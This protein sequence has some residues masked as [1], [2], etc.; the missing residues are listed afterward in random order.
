M[1]IFKSKQAAFTL[2]EIILV[3]LILSVI[4]CLAIPNFGQTYSQLQL[5]QTTE[6]LA[7]LM[8][9]AQTFAISN[10]Q[11]VQL[12]FDSEFSS[13]WLNKSTADTSV[14]DSSFVRINGRMGRTFDIPRTIK[15]KAENAYIL[16]YPDGKIDKVRIDVCQEQKCL[17][18]S[19]K[20]QKGYV[21]VFDAS[22]LDD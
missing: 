14:A 2:I 12:E 17:A 16:F 18:I 10:S 5:K 20:E 19:T 4:A 1:Q 9:Y 13:Y 22:L 11:N 6:D 7:Y 3:V 15:I 21:R 8:R